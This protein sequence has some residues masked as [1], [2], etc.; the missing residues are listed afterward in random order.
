MSPSNETFGVPPVRQVPVLWF[1]EG[2]ATDWLPES[3]L[4][5]VSEQFSHARVRGGGHVRGQA[6]RDRRRRH[7]NDGARHCRR[8][9]TLMPSRLR[10]PLQ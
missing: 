1:S 7:R 9:V 3:L 10:A 8:W 2:A 4:A 5:E 6:D